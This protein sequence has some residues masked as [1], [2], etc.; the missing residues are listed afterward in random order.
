[1][2]QLFDATP[3][4]DLFKSLTL[5]HCMASAALWFRDVRTLFESDVVNVVR[6]HLI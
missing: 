4:A 5:Q 2:S 1:M 3:S 6:G